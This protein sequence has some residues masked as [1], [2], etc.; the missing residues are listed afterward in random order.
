[1]SPL[2][3]STP[4][5]NLLMHLQ[6]TTISVTCATCGRSFLA[7]RLNGVRKTAKYCSRGCCARRPR[8]SFED[9]FWKRVD[10]TES[11]WLW[12][13]ARMP[14]GYGQFT[15]DG[16]RWLVHRKAYELLI[17]PIPPG[18]DLHHDMAG[19]CTSRSCVNPAHLIPLPRLDHVH[20]EPPEVNNATK[21][22]CK[23]GHPFTPEN[24]YLIRTGGRMCRVCNTANAR[25]Y[26]NANKMPPLEFRDADQASEEAS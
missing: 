24:T 8:P 7:R 3:P 17:G 11:C 21:T 18:L 20:Q 1:M 14:K 13:G 15:W 10:K 26:R 22:R 5:R 9:R 12:T 6:S 25:R 19:G 4:E 23:H 2:L 16:R